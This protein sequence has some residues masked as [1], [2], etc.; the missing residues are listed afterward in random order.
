MIEE[1]FNQIEI[2]FSLE[3]LSKEDINL[4]LKLIEQTWE[5]SKEENKKRDI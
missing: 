3:E 2:Y 4:F 1:F 5:I